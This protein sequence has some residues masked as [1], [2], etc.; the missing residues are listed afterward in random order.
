MLPGAVSAFQSAMVLM[1]QHCDIQEVTRMAVIQ[2][3]IPPRL[4][5]IHWIL[6]RSFLM[7][8]D[9]MRSGMPP[10]C[11]NGGSPLPSLNGQAPFKTGSVP[12]MMMQKN[13]NLVVP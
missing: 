4:Q 5:L 1:W 13:M 11:L 7:I 10:G 6:H 3:I 8:L 9:S 2:M 12:A